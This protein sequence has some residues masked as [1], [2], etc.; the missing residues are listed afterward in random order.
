M[1]AKNFLFTAVLTF[2][3]ILFAT[4]VSGQTTNVTTGTGT[5]TGGSIEGTVLSTPH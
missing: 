2:G 1:K 4:N 3:A 5:A